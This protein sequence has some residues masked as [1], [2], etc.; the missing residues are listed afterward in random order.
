MAGSM[1]YC[2]GVHLTCSVSVDAPGRK[3]G[4]T[5]DDPCNIWQCTLAEFES[6]RDANREG[7]AS[8]VHETR[9]ILSHS[10]PLCVYRHARHVD[11]YPAFIFSIRVP[12]LESNSVPGR[13]D[14]EVLVR[15]VPNV[16]HHQKRSG[17]EILDENESITVWCPVPP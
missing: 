11:V 2:Q 15:Y 16:S 4:V 1:M 10:I 9:F 6:Y 3:P 17:N 13:Y 12:T 5:T 14:M 7:P 8:C